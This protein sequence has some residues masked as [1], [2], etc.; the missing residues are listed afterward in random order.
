MTWAPCVKEA[1]LTPNFAGEGEL[2]GVLLEAV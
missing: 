2:L 1:L